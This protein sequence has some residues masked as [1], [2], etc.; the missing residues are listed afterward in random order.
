MPTEKSQK[1]NS[2]QAKSTPSSSSDSKP[3]QGQTAP[4][5]SQ[6]SQAPTPP[7]KGTTEGSQQPEAN[8]RPEART[9]APRRQTMGLEDLAALKYAQAV[10]P[11]TIKHMDG[12]TD[13]SY[14]MPEIEQNMVHVE[15]DLVLPYDPATGK[16][17]SAPYVQKYWPAEY[18][19]SRERGGF[20]GYKVRVLH[21]PAELERLEAQ[22]ARKKQATE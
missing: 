5:T 12:N 8:Q 13:T 3:K 18:L 21:K 20:A 16:R 10:E 7:A 15:L 4:E 2:S 9:H 11:E 17:K 1:T 14:R 6:E 22:A 19:A